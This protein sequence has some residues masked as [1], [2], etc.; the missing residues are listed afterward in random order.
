MSATIAALYPAPQSIDSLDEWGN[1]DS[2]RWSLDSNVW[3][4]CGVYGLTVSEAA[5]GMDATAW[6]VVVEGALSGQADASG[7]LEGAAAK[8][9]GTFPGTAAASQS[10]DGNRVIDGS[11]DA[12]AQGDG[13]LDGGGV[14]NGDQRGSAQ[15]SGDVEAERLIGGMAAGAAVS[16]ERF[17]YGFIM[18]L[19]A[20]GTAQGTA[21][22]FPEYKGWGWLADAQGDKAWT[23]DAIAPAPWTV[24]TEGGAD[25]AQ[26]TEDPA[27]WTP[28]RTEAR[29]WTAAI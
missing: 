18:P 29:P 13:S 6:V 16:A 21:A 14:V 15:S 12:G 5:L 17:A 20:A 8:D 26:V 11:A 3:T 1:L 10:L 4:K 19:T 7:S 22:I 9:A 27:V 2:L 28:T 24:I 23:P 25:W